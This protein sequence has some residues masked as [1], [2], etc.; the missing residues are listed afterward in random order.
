M[1][2]LTL[3]ELIDLHSRIIDQTAEHRGCVTWADWNLPSR[4]PECLSRE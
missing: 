4:S 1:R 2:F 3:A